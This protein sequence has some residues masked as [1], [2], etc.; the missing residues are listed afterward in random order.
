MIL[1]IAIVTTGAVVATVF[2]SSLRFAYRFVQMQAKAD[3]ENDPRAEKRRIL[4]RQR[5]TWVKAAGE[6]LGSMRQQNL[7]NAAKIDQELIKL[8][9]EESFDPVTGEVHERAYP[10]LGDVI[11]KGRNS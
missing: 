6:S 5:A 1:E 8:S 9:E 2:A 7:I 4:E 11:P 3:H 10:D